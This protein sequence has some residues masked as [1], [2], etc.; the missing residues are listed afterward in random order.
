LPRY[1]IAERG[2]RDVAEQREE[3]LDD[4]IDVGA[5]SSALT[6]GPSPAQGSWADRTYV[7]NVHL[8]HPD[9]LHGAERVC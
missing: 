6:P 3:L 4:L 9:A 7:P 2:E 1:I 8:A 5:G